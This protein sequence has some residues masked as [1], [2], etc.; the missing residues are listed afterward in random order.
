MLWL[1][2]DVFRS[3]QKQRSFEDGSMNRV[4][5]GLDDVSISGSFN[6]LQNLD[7]YGEVRIHWKYC[8]LAERELM[9]NN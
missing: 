1:Q 5:C 7:R 9:F 4:L 2:G 6:K 3:K 8:T